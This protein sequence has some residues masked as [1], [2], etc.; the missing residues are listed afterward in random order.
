M[1]ER[2]KVRQP[3]LF[4]RG[5]PLQDR[6]GEEFFSQL[7]NSPGVYFMRD[8]L[9]SLLYIG[10]SSDL[11]ARLKSYRHVSPETHARRTVRLV[12]RIA[13]I[14]LEL[15]DSPQ[16]AIERERLLLL[17]H[18]PPFNRAGVWVGEPWW[19]EITVA[20]ETCAT[21]PVQLELHRAAP[22]PQERPNQILGPFPAGI[23]HRLSHLLRCCLRWHCPDLEMTNFPFGI[24]RSSPPLPLT[25]S[26]PAK[27]LSEFLRD[28]NLLC[29][30]QLPTWEIPTAP[31]DLKAVCPT[32]AYW[33][34]EFTQLKRWCQP[35]RPEAGC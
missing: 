10:Q 9:G 5:S 34:E 3:W 22:T 32:E 7:P 35:R 31:T 16:E 13:Q 4:P 11:Q 18:K 8:A 25:V 20:A 28:L 19:L 14:D 12:A 1:P 15:C 27:C 26:T 33:H 29:D 24:F 6:L 21:V 17:E 2:R 30:R 23:R